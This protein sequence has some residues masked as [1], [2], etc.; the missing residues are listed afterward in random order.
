M[1]RQSKAQE[2]GVVVGFPH[3]HLNTVSSMWKYPKQEPNLDEHIVFE[4]KSFGGG[5]SSHVLKETTSCALWRQWFI[6]QMQRVMK[7]V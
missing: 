2:T 5:A 1:K 3:G 6:S 7:A 4:R